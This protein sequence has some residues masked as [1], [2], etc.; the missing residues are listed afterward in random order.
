[1]EISD[2]VDST[3]KDTVDNCRGEYL[4]C[5]DAEGAVAGLLVETLIV[6]LGWQQLGS[7]QPKKMILSGDH[8]R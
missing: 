8:F 5:E 2:R 6:P 1:M 4:D 7:D 3:A